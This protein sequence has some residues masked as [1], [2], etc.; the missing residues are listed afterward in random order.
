MKPKYVVLI[1]ACLASAALAAPKIE[2]VAVDPSQPKFTG[3]K[4]PEVEVSVNVSRTKFDKGGCDA[5]VEFGD[6]EGRTLD[7][8]VAAKR[9]VKHTYKKGGSY[10]VVA[11]G[12]GKRPCDGMAQ[13][14]VVVQGPPPPPKPAAKKAE[15]KKAEKKAPAKK[16][17]AKKAPAKKDEKK[18]DDTSK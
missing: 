12:A 10:T 14:P 3:D 17:P 15:A 6:G 16:A 8:D 5:R 13:M 9:N 18:K 7:F 1:A 11:K 4:P 2:N